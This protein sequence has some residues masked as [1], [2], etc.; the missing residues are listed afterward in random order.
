MKTEAYKKWL[1]YIHADLNAAET[2][3]KSAIR[4]QSASWYHFAPIIWHAHQTV[5]KS[6]KAILAAKEIELLK[7][8]DLS[9]LA[10]LARVGNE[11]EKS[12]H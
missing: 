2:L 4:M 8:H 5:E 3:Y 10:E 6:L 7:I 11:V 9:R 12:Y 1:P